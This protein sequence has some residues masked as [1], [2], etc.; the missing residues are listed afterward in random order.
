MMT[1]HR[2][3]LQSVL[4]IAILFFACAVSS[5]EKKTADPYPLGTALRVLE[6]DLT[7]KQY[8]DVLATMIPTDLA[9]E[10][11]RIG[12]PDNYEVFLKEHGGKEKVLAD[13]QLRAAY[14]RRL[15]IAEQFLDLMRS[16][17]KNRK[18]APPF[19]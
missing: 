19:D 17:Y 14:E 3:P 1:T 13:P 11:K 12:T 4:L 5:Q 16:A 18:V 2:W 10:W 7:S 6:R 8:A 9:A 15:K